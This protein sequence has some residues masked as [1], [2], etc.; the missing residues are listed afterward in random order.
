MTLALPLNLAA[1]GLYSTIVRDMAVVVTHNYT[2]EEQIINPDDLACQVDEGQWIVENAHSESLAR[3]RNSDCPQ[4]PGVLLSRYFPN[5]FD[6][7]RT[8]VPK[9]TSSCTARPEW[10]TFEG[11]TLA[12]VGGD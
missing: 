1:D 8:R 4:H 9:A 6:K 11:Q 12:S 10:R 2:K 5:Q 7:K 3:L